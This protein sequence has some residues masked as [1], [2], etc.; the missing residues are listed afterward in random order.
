M[1]ILDDYTFIYKIKSGSKT[2]NGGF[3]SKRDRGSANS[4]GEFIIGKNIDSLNYVENYNFG[5]SYRYNINDY[6]QK[7]NYQTK[8]KFNGIDINSGTNQGT[9]GIAIGGGYFTL[10]NQGVSELYDGVFYFAYLFN[11]SLDEQE[12]KEFIRKYIDSEYLLP[13]EQTTE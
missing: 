9:K 2:G 3:I 12:I 5:Y 6:S 1:P 10:E 13:S 7:I 11:R 8:Y 4:F